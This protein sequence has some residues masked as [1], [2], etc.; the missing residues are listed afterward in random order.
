MA[1]D[2]WSHGWSLIP[3]RKPD[4]KPERKSLRMGLRAHHF[5][6]LKFFLYYFSTLQFL[7]ELRG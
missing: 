4:R 6:T 5:Q 3:A 1:S 7:T 2:K